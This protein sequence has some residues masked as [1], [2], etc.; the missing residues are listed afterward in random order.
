MNG[1]NG[2]GLTGRIIKDLC[3]I[4]SGGRNGER[5]VGRAVLVGKGGGK[6]RKL[7]MNNNK[8]IIIIRQNN[9]PYTLQEPCSDEKECYV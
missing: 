7:Y 4:T 9:N 5:E 3:T 8:I 2:E 6:G 1:G